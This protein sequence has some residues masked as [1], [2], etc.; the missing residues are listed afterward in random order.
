ME[1]QIAFSVSKLQEIASQPPG[2]VVHMG[3]DNIVLV[4]E[5]FFRGL[6]SRSAKRHLQVPDLLKEANEVEGWEIPKTWYI[7]RSEVRQYRDQFKAWR[8]AQTLLSE[9]AAVVAMQE[10]A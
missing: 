5:E 1:N 9:F 4:P 7:Q 10:V 3:G 8:T 2:R 6:Q